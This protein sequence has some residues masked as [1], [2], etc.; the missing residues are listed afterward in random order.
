MISDGCLNRDRLPSRRFG[1]KSTSLTA[2]TARGAGLPSGRVSTALRPHP[3][4]PAALWAPAPGTRTTEPGRAREALKRQ[5]RLWPR[6]I[7]LKVAHWGCEE[8]RLCDQTAEREELGGRVK[9]FT[10]ETVHQGESHWA[11]GCGHREGPG[12]WQQLET[13]R[14]SFWLFFCR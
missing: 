1:N 14:D 8:L 13:F 10:P 3:G 5:K 11:G 7:H 12:C 4:P 6:Q 2:Q 9:G